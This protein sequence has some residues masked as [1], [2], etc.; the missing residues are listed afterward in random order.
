[1]RPALRGRGDAGAPGPPARKPAAGPGTAREWCV[2]A[3]ARLD[4]DRP[5]T[6]LQAAREAIR[7]DPSLD[8]AHRL[9][10]L[11]LER[12]GRD[13]DAVVSAEQAVRLAPGAWTARLRL[14]GALRRVPGRWREAS[15]QAARA[16]WFAPGEPDAH[17]L[18]GDL[19]LVRGEHRRAAGAYRTALRAA[20]DHPG[21][22][23]NL[24]LALLRW[25]R[26]RTHHDP[27]WT[28]DPKDTGRTRRA[29]A[30]WSRQVRLLLAV[31]LCAAAAL[32]HWPGHHAQA[33]FAGV[34][35]LLLVLAPT[36]R[37]A[38]RVRLWSHVPRMLAR[39]VWLTVSVALAPL[40]V[41]AYAAAVLTL[42]AFPVA[43]SAGSG[44]DP[45][46]AGLS[47]LVVF[48]GPAV[49]TLRL[50]A[51]A[52]RGRPVRAVAEFAA[53][54][55]ERTARRDADIGVWIITMRAWSLVLLGAAAALTISAP[56]PVAG[57]LAVP[58]GLAVARR[59][60]RLG[61]HLREIL[62]ADRL[63]GLALLLLFAASAALA[64]AGVGMTVSGSP[65]GSLP[66]SLPGSP[67]VSLSGAVVVWGWRAG[68]GAL[69]A[70]V[71]VFGVR[72]AWAW[73]RG[74]PGPWRGALIMGAGCGGRLPG[75]ARP[76]VGLSDEVRRA[77]VSSRSV[78]LSY[79]GDGGPRALAVGAVT[80][81]GSGGELR[82]IVAD[83]A[84]Q[85]AERDPKVA[86]F[87][88]DP[89]GRR[90]WAEVRGIAVGDPAAEILR[91]TPEQV[92]VGEYPGRHQGRRR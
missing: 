29:L 17:V 53:A 40:T 79:A 70:V 68:A 89:A 10:S 25:E 16:V 62:A 88:A 37:Q 22:R 20:H 14:G 23:I 46:W 19:A 84:W 1:M 48:N 63:L 61:G 73:W 33:R 9:A 80:S 66:G 18:A 12:L 78:V 92:I 6:A 15:A 39:D 77:F 83:E 31:A 8:W 67:A 82:L 57:V 91:V 51:E 28:A 74:A 43:T 42:P 3:I 7:R 5:E 27:A 36:V 49:M 56:W 76:S 13:T 87:A 44:P 32:A 45:L 90:F 55:S 21:A 47:G 72:A 69:G 24:G 11:A 50:L 59:R 81:V 65:P 54:M 52:W 41:A 75:D 30:V 86:V 85:A 60:A 38:R 64:A 35:V 4:A 26:R 2:T 71:V 34:A 58:A